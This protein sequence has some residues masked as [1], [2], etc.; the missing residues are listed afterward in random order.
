MEGRRRHPIL[1]LPSPGPSLSAHPCLI[2]SPITSFEVWT[3]PPGS[4]RPSL[5][6]SDWG[7]QDDSKARLEALA[8]QGLSPQN[9]PPDHPPPCSPH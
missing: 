6:A 1:P 4:H 7:S 3:P 8:L 9:V 2:L 5:S